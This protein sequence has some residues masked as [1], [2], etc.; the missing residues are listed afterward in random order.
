MKTKDKTDTIKSKMFGFRTRDPKTIEELNKISNPSDFL[1]DLM[2]KYF[3]GEL[4]TLEQ[5][6][7][8]KEMSELKFRNLKA[9][10]IKKEISAK[11]EMIHDLHIPPADVV[12]IMNSKKTIYEVKATKE[13]IQPD[14]RLRCF[15]CGIILELRAYDYLQVEDYEKH[16]KEIHQ[17]ELTELERE[18]MLKILGEVAN[19]H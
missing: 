16:I 8:I 15:T 3:S 14:N 9:Q 12:E 18:S 6:L 11:R 5:S 7:K 13:I 1:S 17:R 10:V 19:E 4:I 2:K